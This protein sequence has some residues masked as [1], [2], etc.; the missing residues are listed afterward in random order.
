VRADLQELAGELGV[1]VEYWDQSGQHKVVSE[2]TL[3]AVLAAMGVD[4]S[5]ADTTANALDDLRRRAWRRTLP[6]VYITREGKRAPGER[7]V[8]LHLSDDD[9]VS[10]DVVL[11]DGKRIADCEQIANDQPQRV[12]DGSIM[13]EL[14]F[15]L[16]A[17]LPLG[18]HT[19]VV[20]AKGSQIAACPLVVCPDRIA[21]LDDRL[22]GLMAQLYS[23]RSKDSWAQGDFQDLATLAQWAGRDMGG[24][25]LLINPLHAGSPVA[26]L[27]P[28]PYLPVTRRFP[29]PFYLRVEQVP[30]FI[31]APDKIRE[32]IEQMAKPLRALNTSSDLLDRDAVWTAKS[33]ALSLLF[34]HGMTQ[35]RREAF[36]AFRDSEGSGLVDFATW[37]ALVEQ[38]VQQGWVSAKATDP[39]ASDYP[40]DLPPRGTSEARAAAA[41]V[42]Q[43]IDFHMWLQFLVDEQ[44]AQSQQAAREA[45][46]SIGIMHDLAVGVHPDG[47]DAWALSDVLAA[48]VSVGAPPDMYNQQGQDWSQ[49]PWRPDALAEAAFIP[50]RD[51]LRTVLRH[52]GALRIDHILG[53]FRLWWIPNGMSAT[54][55][56]YVRYDHEALL[57]ILAL[58][59]HRT[60]AL[61]VGED[62]G[63]LEAWVQEVLRER[64]LLGTSIL[65]FE[66]DNGAPMP[67]EKFRTDVLASVTVH[68]L[69][70][71][72]GYLRGE[73]VRIRADL[74]L[75]SRSADEEWADH[76]RMIT[77]WISA[78]QA[79]GFLEPGHETSE[80]RV[81]VALHRYL[82]S[83]PAKAIGIALVDVVGD[84]R[85]Q[86]QPGTDQE[87]PNWRVPL[88]DAFGRAV[89]LEDLPGSR[90]AQRLAE[91]LRVGLG[92]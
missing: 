27:A 61:I 9:A 28:S 13:V 8:W 51:M 65:W 24:D 90:G 68:D 1:A 43:R 60:G 80:S 22:W 32:R 5:T 16:P 85:A 53:L 81:V 12:V 58:E 35:S 26:P 79:S 30:E 71:T 88:C 11:E 40:I 76:E 33:D 17:D 70:P 20:T 73:H 31:N 92:T 19:I 77:G 57:G 72:L 91:L 66:S 67:A 55:G 42:Q 44:L 6:P 14:S 15:R 89:L 47:A 7:D 29:S 45:G 18:W 59:A 63:T 62:L 36:E 78:L 69:P 48:G 84:V 23:V 2:A 46:M 52:A 86:N 34:E 37:C 50:F 10:L 75:L 74:D 25:F 56:T 3:L 54:E 41:A 39:L 38:R 83:T 21:G 49:P 82:M 64:G 4:G 87:Y